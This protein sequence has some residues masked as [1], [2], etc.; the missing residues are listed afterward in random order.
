M[1]IMGV[2]RYINPVHSSHIW[3]KNL[4]PDWHSLG[5][6]QMTFKYRIF[7]AIGTAPATGTVKARGF[8]HAIAKLQNRMWPFMP[9]SIEIYAQ[10]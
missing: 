3:A 7:M 10:D 6:A 9:E 4:V 8:K 2:N 1:L 5:D